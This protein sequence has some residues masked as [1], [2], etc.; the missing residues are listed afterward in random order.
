MTASGTADFRGNVGLA[1][2]DA[3]ALPRSGWGAV[4]ALTLCVAALIASEFM[5][6]S[7][8]TPIAGDLRI[9]EGRA[10]Q[11][12]A[13]SGLFAVLTSLG[14][15][16]ATRG[17][18]RRNV[19]LSLTLLMMASGA[20]VALAPNAGV[21]M[22]GRALLGVVV[23]GFWS[24]SAATVMRLVPGEDV[25]RAMGLL[26][27]GNALAATIAAPLG[28]FLAQYVGWRGAFFAVVP[29]A[30]LTLVWLFAT[31]PA[32]PFEGGPAGGSVFR[33]LRRPRVPAGMLGVALLFLGQFA[34]FTYLR[35]FLETV[36]RVDVSTLS[37]ILLI[38]GAAGLAGTWLIGVVLRTRLFSVLVAMP[39]AMAAIAVAL[40]VFG[41]SPVA[42]ALLLVGW[43]LIG[44]AAPVAWWTW[45]SRALP[46]DAEAGGGLMVAVIQLAIALGATAGGVLYDASG[47]R[48]TFAVSAAAL[49]ASAVLAGI[50]WHGLRGRVRIG[51]DARVSAPRGRRVPRGLGLLLG[52]LVL[53]GCE[54]QAA[55]PSVSPG[56]VIADAAPPTRRPGESRMWMTVGERRFAITLADNPA[57]RAF[58]AQLPLTLD[59]SELN[60]NE[61]HA[62]LREALP[63]NAS[64][65]G[66]IRN[67]DLMLYGANTLVLFYD[68]FDS[69]Y[70][71]TRLG[72][73]DDPAGLPQ[74]LGRRGVR[75]VF[76]G[77]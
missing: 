17:I 28:S 52:L 5:P 23:G 8:L 21:F 43:G 77:S 35:P 51:G 30:A 20:M 55:A 50:A 33:V 67:G 1:G 7:L 59:M 29:L 63:A 27:G 19:L 70:P 9:T 32:M 22:A 26:N 36:T 56:A 41:G 4:F 15:S 62:E 10:G 38:S 16:T 46:D 37:L 42:V 3:A 73:V 39:L 61:K 76:S 60:G 64:R 48:S 6:V 72:R 57:A 69:S 31:L 12:I 75:V 45:L 2:R 47:Y 68:T 24:M 25:P 14:I 11:A 71:Y 54:A 40:T 66:T 18:D 13:V 49:C 74:A 58:A 65:P 34:L 53:G 44:T